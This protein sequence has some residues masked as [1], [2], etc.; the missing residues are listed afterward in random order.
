MVASPI[1][2]MALSVGV[3]GC[4]V[5]VAVIVAVCRAKKEDLPQ[6]MRALMR[7]RT[8]SPATYAEASR[9]ARRAVKSLQTAVTS[10]EWIAFYCPT[11]QLWHREI[12]VHGKG[13]K[14]APSR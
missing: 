6:I 9:R 14:T 13:R 1:V 8:P 4:L 11:L 2:V 3:P 12:T 5:G 7:T 10:A